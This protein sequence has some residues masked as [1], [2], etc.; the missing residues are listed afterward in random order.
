MNDIGRIISQLEE[1]RDSV[2]RAISALRAIT[3]DHAGRES[4]SSASQARPRKRRLSPAGRKR[5]AEGVKRRWAAI[6]AAKA[7]PMAKAASKTAKTP[8]K[9]RISAA[10]RKRIAE[11]AKKMWAA[12]RAAATKASAK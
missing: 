10:G 4:K 12:R 6:K 1:Q 11:A 2:E 7:G 3:G 9:R 8:A 5:I